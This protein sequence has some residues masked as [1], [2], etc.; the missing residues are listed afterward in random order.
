MG[1]ARWRGRRCVA[2]ALACAGCRDQPAH[3]G[4]DSGAAVDTVVA[5]GVRWRPDAPDAGPWDPP[6]GVELCA[7]RA[8]RTEADFFEIQSDSCAWTVFSQPLRA[9]VAAGDRVGF[10]LWT[11]DLWSP[12]PYTATFG[13]AFGDEI[14]WQQQVEVPGPGGI[15][16]LEATVRSAQP[17][18]TPAT[19]HLDNHGI[20]SWRINDIELMAP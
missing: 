13:F 6:D 16:Q 14:V 18:G 3:L 19:L 15:V 2:V 7:E 8:W 1:R 20:N 11:D 5:A 10:V 12:T 9:A 4:A 17:E